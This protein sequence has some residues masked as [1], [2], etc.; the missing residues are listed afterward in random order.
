MLFMAALN[1][2]TVPTGGSNV[3]QRFFLHPTAT[4]FLEMMHFTV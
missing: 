2:L 4:D 3:L 1:S